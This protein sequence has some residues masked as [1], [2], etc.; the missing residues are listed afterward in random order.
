MTSRYF[1][2][3]LCLVVIAVCFLVGLKIGPFLFP[4][5]TQTNTELTQTNAEN[6]A[7]SVSAL[8]QTESM[9]SPN[10]SVLAEENYCVSDIKF[11]DESDKKFCSQKS[12]IGGT[13]GLEINLTAEKALL[14][15]NGKLTSILPLA[16]QSQ[17]GKWYQAPTG[18]YFAGVKKE[19]HVSSIFPVTMPYA[20]QYYEDFFIHGIPYYKNGEQV[21]SSF[22]GGC[23]R[24]ADGIAE[25]IFNF[26]N[27]GDP[28]LV[29]KTFDD[30]SL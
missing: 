5:Y 9:L 6:E 7:Q 10:E 11:S 1:E 26:I 20:F 8:S 15:E 19:K 24:F 30:L 23:L 18:Y 22:T 13:K 3:F 28:V 27:P 17:E 25:Q 21:S 4:N 2:I 14:Y 29:Y 16:Y 12:K